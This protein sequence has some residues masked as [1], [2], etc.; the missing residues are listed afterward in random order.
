MVFSWLVRIYFGH[1]QTDFLTFS[2][3]LHSGYQTR[4]SS[5]SSKLPACF[6][7]EWKKYLSP[8]PSIELKYQ[9]HC[10]FWRW[11]KK[12][13]TFEIWGYE[14]EKFDIIMV[15]TT[16]SC[17]KKKYCSCWVKQYWSYWVNGIVCLVVFYFSKR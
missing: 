9:R 4:V 13:K 15:I 14:M 17:K 1:K 3:S 11:R 7:A 6:R 5:K 16:L 10:K 12:L 2:I 8:L